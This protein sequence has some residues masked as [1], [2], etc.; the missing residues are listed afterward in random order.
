MTAGGARGE[1]LDKSAEQLVDSRDVYSD[2]VEEEEVV[3]PEER[4]QTKAMNVSKSAASFVKGGNYYHNYL[5]KRNAMGGEVGK[6]EEMFTDYSH[7]AATTERP[8]F[9]RISLASY[10]SH[11]ATSPNNVVFRTRL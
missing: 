2:D 4:V 5:P 7:S 6:E 3:F 8:R 9:Q 1:R 10:S 11:E